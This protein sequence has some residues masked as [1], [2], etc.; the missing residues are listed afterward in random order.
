[1]NTTVE[2]VLIT[3]YDGLLRIAEIKEGTGSLYQK[4][5]AVLWLSP[6]DLKLLGVNIGKPVELRSAAG[7]I[8]AQAKADPNSKPGMGYMP[9][10]LYSLS[11]TSYDPAKSRFPDFKRIEV[12]VLPTEQSITPISEIERGWIA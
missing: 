1:M 3:Y 6:D 10:S 9:F 4:L 8:V 12:T 2:L 5:A 11:L 7:S